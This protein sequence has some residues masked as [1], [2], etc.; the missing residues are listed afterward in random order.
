MSSNMTYVF[1]VGGTIA[2]PFYK[3]ILIL[4]LIRSL[5]TSFKVLII[6]QTAHKFRISLRVLL[7]IRV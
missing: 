2:E 6:A 5:K 4:S 1:I 7:G 3:I